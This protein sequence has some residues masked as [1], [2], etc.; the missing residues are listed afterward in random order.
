M[1]KTLSKTE[2]LSCKLYYLRYSYSNK[3]MYIPL[4]GCDVPRSLQGG[5]AAAGIFARTPARNGPAKG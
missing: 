3:C 1:D 4:Y 2:N 5:P